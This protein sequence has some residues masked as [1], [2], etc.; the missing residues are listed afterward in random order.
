MS[1]ISSYPAGVPCW[2]DTFQP[3]PK[4][5]VQFYGPLLGWHFDAPVAMPSGLAGTYRAARC[6]GR[7]VAGIGQAPAGVP[8]AVW[9]TYV[10][11]DDIDETASLVGAAGGGLIV[12]PTAH[13]GHGR[14]AVLTDPVGVAF[15]VWQP[16]ARRGAEW[17]NEPGSWTMSTLHT[18]APETS[19]TFYGRTF[20]WRLES[21]PDAP[22][23]YWRLHGHVGG[24][25]GQSMPRDV[26]GV[27][28][29]IEGD[30]PTPPHWSVAL[31]VADADATA[32]RAAELG[33]TVL[34]AP[35]DTPGFRS[36]VIVDPQG[37]VVAV[38][39]RGTAV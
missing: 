38:T 21:V 17:V 32:H 5:A 30:A 10:A 12:G 7:L 8:S 23:A 27:L 15:G 29:P 34:L 28:A 31:L 24:K 13:G 25:P 1:K 9:T 39:A 18:Q 35:T 37:G 14:M 6:G 22:I 20:G 3:D 11:V 2:V 19:A 4:A 26:V 33:G 36:A 16:G